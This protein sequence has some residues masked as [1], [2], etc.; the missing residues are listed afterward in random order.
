M[1]HV[2]CKNL[3]MP[4]VSIDVTVFI[5]LSMLNSKGIIFIL[6]ALNN[7][8]YCMILIYDSIIKVNYIIS[9]ILLTSIT[10][11]TQR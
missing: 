11:Q 8:F 3:N 7:E 4:T 9:I 2:T 6:P 1:I 10:K 5:I